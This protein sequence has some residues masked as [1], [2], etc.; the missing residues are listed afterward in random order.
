MKVNNKIRK[1][2][3]QKLE[4]KKHLIDP[5]YKNFVYTMLFLTVVLILF[6]VNNS[7]SEPERG[8]YPPYYKQNQ[9]GNTLKKAPNFTLPSIDKKN[10]SLSDYAGKVVLL[11]FWA[12][13]CPPCRKGIPDLVELKKEYGDAIE[14]IGIS[15]DGITYGGRTLKDVEPF[16]K[17]SKINYPVVHGNTEVIEKY[18]G[19]NSIPTYFIITK[20]GFIHSTYVGLVDKSVYK[21]EI[22]KLLKKK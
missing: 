8:P 2:A 10:I 12:T 20:D 17:A 4:E 3:N 16:V 11:D 19:I 22:E 9:S 1:K 7:R 21:A 13:W 5:K 15:L 14:I 18:G 6:I